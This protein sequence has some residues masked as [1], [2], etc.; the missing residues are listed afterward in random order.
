M[1]QIK[2]ITVNGNTYEIAD[3]DAAHIDDSAVDTN[4]WSSRKISDAIGAAQ[5]EIIRR[6]CPAFSESG[7]V[8]T[9][10]PVEGYPLDAVTR[11]QPVQS[12]SGDPSPANIRPITGHTSCK[13]YR[14]GKNF[15]K[16]PYVSG[17]MTTNGI[18]FTL[19]SDGTI[20]ANG[21]ATALAQFTCAR[22]NATEGLY[23]PAG[24]FTLS[25]CP[26][27]GGPNKYYVRAIGNTYGLD[28]TDYGSGATGTV[29]GGRS[30]TGVVIRIAS[31]YTANNLI[32]KPQ[33]EM[34]SIATERAPYQGSTFTLDLGQTVYGGS[35][36]WK[37][38]VLTVD[39][40][41]KTFD[42]TE[43]IYQ[44]GSNYRF[45]IDCLDYAATHYTN[46]VYCSHYSHNTSVYADTADQIG[47]IATDDKVYMRLGAASESTTVDQLKAF[48]AEQY[49]AGTPVQV[50]Y[51]L[52]TPITVQLTP[53]EILA[54]SGTNTLY[55]DTGDTTV[56]GRADLPALLQSLT[57]AQ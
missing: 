22:D 5:R 27:G 4:A 6:L 7:G 49:A 51:Q 31:G 55:S 12:G 37:T 39:W 15:L 36:D 43:K 16:R 24:T 38:G 14:H 54:L 2:T 20:T 52:A 29:V 19:N 10:Q 33:I 1:K 48:L 17:T 13:L 23:L 32:F 53:T 25:G 30:S 3:P 42:G 28:A 46:K 41:T 21:T 11:I 44:Y 57:A 50:C 9:C 47:I 26:A 18:T 34:G 8:V 56:T 40:Y 45:R 35:L